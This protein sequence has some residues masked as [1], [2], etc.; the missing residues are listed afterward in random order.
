VSAS[1]FFEF[2]LNFLNFFYF[3]LIFKKNLKK[4]KFCHVSSWHRATWQWQCHVAMTVPRGNDSATCHYLGGVIFSFSIWSLYFIFCLN[5]V[6]IFV[7]IIQFRP[8]PN[9]NKNYKM[10]YK[11]FIKFDFFIQIDIFIIYFQ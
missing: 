4:L 3:L 7:K 6:P 2:F 10:L 1:G 9:W 8:P 5:L 11:Y